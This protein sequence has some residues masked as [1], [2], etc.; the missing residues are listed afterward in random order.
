MRILLVAACACLLAACSSDKST[1][2]VQSSARSGGL[3]SWLWP[4]GGDSSDDQSAD[5]P[6][7]GVNSYLWRATLDTLNFMPLASADPVGGVVISDWY[8]APEKPDEHIKVTVYILDKRL[9]A[10]ALKVSVFRQVR[11]ANGWNDAQ[12]N[13][14]TGVKLENAILARARDLRLATMPQ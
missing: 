3:I 11:N 1:V 13:P 7:L 10:D 14:D 5:G 4:F 8:A 2:S 12:V 9:R 6:Q